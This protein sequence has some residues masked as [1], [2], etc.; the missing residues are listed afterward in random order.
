VA[1]AKIPQCGTRL[2]LFEIGS[3]N[4]NQ[5]EGG[6]AMQKQ[7]QSSDVFVDPVCLMKVSPGSP[8]IK[9]TYKTKTY[10]FCAEGCKKE[11]ETDPDI[12]LS[13]KTLKKKGWWGKYLDRLE[14]ATGG[15]SMKCH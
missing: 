3:S 7:E 11:F 2:A 6:S 10:H 15:K 9:S 4:N 14:K 12:F 13:P 1:C 5:G 8:D